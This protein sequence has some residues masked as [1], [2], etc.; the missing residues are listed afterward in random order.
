MDLL[1]KEKAFI[2]SSLLTLFLFV[3]TTTTNEM[4]E[5]GVLMDQFNK[6]QGDLLRGHFPP[7]LPPKLIHSSDV[8]L[9][10]QY[11]MCILFSRFVLCMSITDLPIQTGWLEFT[12]PFVFFINLKFHVV[13]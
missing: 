8:D 13:L 7:D 2:S 1:S 3:Q 11:C 12:W 6:E 4:F 9:K 5:G 10:V